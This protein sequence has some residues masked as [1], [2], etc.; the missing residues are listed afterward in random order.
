M[1][2]PVPLPDT[3]RRKLEADGR[4]PAELDRAAY[5]GVARAA[6]RRA[7]VDD[8]PGMLAAQC[9]MSGLLAPVREHPF[10]PGR[11]FRFD[12]AWPERYVAVEV[13]G[14][15]FIGG[16]HTSGA[17]FETDCVKLSEAAARGWRVLRVTPRH[18]K[19]GQALGWVTRALLGDPE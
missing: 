2:R 7:D 10:W 16:R 4:M 1:A 15:A 8:F 6:T 11:R 9:R 14:G 12:L 13:D 17:G 3:I 18:V 19:S 5:R